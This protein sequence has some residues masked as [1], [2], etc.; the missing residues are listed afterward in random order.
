MAKQPRGKI[1]RHLGINIY[2]NP[3]YDKLLDRKPN[4]PGKE[5]GNKSRAK[6]SVYG[7]QLKEK[8]KFRFAYGM[9]ERQFRNLYKNASR[10]SGA[11]GD[12]MI[13]LMER[14]FDNTIY[15][16]GFAI[17]R[18]QARQ[19]VSHGYF[20]INGKL[21]NIPSMY[22]KAGD[23]IT[24]REKKGIESLI[25]KNLSAT[26]SKKG[27]WIELDD[28]KLSAKIVVLPQ[29]TDIQPVGKIQSVVEFYSK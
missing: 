26:T 7:E 17:S 10:M 18:A 27:N 21:A 24:T 22:I 8:Q 6:V 20:Y 2:G 9:S 28:Q 19:M 15:R 14:R 1:V 16:M 11:T 12:N 29:S 23:V 3:K 13:S 4:T 5:R 25:R